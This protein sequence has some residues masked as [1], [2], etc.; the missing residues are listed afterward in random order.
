MFIS[1]LSLSLRALIGASN[2]NP[3][4]SRKE[5]SKAL[6]HVATSTKNHFCIIFEDDQKYPL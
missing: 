2:S 3:S 6:G 1:V 5:P 4:I